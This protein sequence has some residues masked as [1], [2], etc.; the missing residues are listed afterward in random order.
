MATHSSI[1]A[2]EISWTEEPGQLSPWSHRELD[3]TEQL[4]MHAHTCTHRYLSYI[5]SYNPIL[6]DS[7]FAPVVS[8][9]ATENF[10][11]W[12]P[13]CLWHTHNIVGFLKFWL[14]FKHFL[15]CLRHVLCIFCPSPRIS[16][17]WF[18]LLGDS[19]LSNREGNGTP[20][21]YFCLENPMDGGAW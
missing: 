13:V 7:F 17:F 4:S 5:L 19:T 8:V 20:L 2:W 9:L 21:Q 1:L 11:I 14:F 15:T 3:M 12:F 10:F 16:H 6:T 18:F